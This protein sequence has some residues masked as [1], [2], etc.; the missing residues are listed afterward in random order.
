MMLLGHVWW[1]W[2]VVFAMWHVVARLVGK[3]L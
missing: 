3:A 2:L 1:H